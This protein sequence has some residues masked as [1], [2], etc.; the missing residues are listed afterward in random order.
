MQTHTHTNS[1]TML[2]FSNPLYS[3]PTHRNSMSELFKQITL[4]SLCLPRS[5][6]LSA[7][8]PASHL[9]SLCPLRII[10]CALS[11]HHGLILSI[12]WCLAHYYTSLYLAAH[13]S[14]NNIDRCL[15]LFLLSFFIHCAPLLSCQNVPSPILQIRGIILF[16]RGKPAAVLTLLED[17]LKKINK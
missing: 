7:H 4:I 16:R 15:H 2:D 6:F 17:K 13:F 11:S 14:T 10:A 12:P 8:T 1:H 5:T 9:F 3:C